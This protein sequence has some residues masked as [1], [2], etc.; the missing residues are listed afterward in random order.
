MAAAALSDEKHPIGEAVNQ[1]TSDREVR[2]AMLLRESLRCLPYEGDRLIHHAEEHDLPGRGYQLRLEVAGLDCEAPDLRRAPVTPQI[3]A[4]E[5]LG[6]LPRFSTEGP[7]LS[8]STAWCQGRIIAG[9]SCNTATNTRSTL[10][11][12]DHC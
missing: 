5:T 10:I 2:L 11:R 8:L 1:G 12:L 4:D 9:L 7:T 3:L 6:T